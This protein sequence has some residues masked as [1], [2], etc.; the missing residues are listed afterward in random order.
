M[1]LSQTPKIKFVAPKHAPKGIDWDKLGPEIFLSLAK[2]LEDHD[3][4]YQDMPF[5][6][7]PEC[8]SHEARKL[9]KG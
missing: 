7:V 6:C 1:R 8:W 5:Y 4:V 3:S 2:A 9:I